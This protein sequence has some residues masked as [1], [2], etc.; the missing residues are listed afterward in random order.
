M[1]IQMNAVVA[2]ERV[3]K[4]HVILDAAQYGILHDLASAGLERAPEVATLL[5]EELERADVRPSAEMPPDVVTIG[6][7]VA[8]RYNDDGHSQTIRLVYPKHADIT[9][10]R[11]SVFTPIGATLLGLAE[12][13]EMEWTTRHGETRS[14]TIL[15]VGQRAA[16]A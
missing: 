9:M 14:L 8:F 7:E 12:G 5:L 1:T 4:P 10:G 2:H 15:K 16:D 3:G 11:V 13:D 6:S